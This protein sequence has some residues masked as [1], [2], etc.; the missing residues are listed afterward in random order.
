VIRINGVEFESVG[1]RLRRL[2]RR[3]GLTTKELA[4]RARMN[5]GYVS[6][7]E[8]SLKVPSIGKL[9]AAESALFLAAGTLTRPAAIHRTP[10]DVL[11]LIPAETL[12]QFLEVA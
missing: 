11:A 1:E 9:E 6:L 4:A 5:G 3:A 10:A 12:K 8:R 2:R 7:V